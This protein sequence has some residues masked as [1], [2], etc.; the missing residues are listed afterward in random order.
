VKDVRIYQRAR[1]VMQADLKHNKHWT[2]E[3]NLSS[4]QYIEP[5]MGW[6][7]C[8]DVNK[9]VGEHLRFISKEKAIAFAK[10]KG[11]SYEVIETNKRKFRPKCYIDDN[12]KYTLRNFSHELRK[13]IREKFIDSLNKD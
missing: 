13:K 4:P 3:Y 1:S 5:L 7:G 9:Q 2:V 6:T 10:R 8:D 11:L 12:D